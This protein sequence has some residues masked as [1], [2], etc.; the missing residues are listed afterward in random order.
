MKTFM[1]KLMM[2]IMTISSFALGLGSNALAATSLVYITPSS[3]AFTAGQSLTIY[4]RVNAQAPING[5]QANLTYPADKFNVSS[6]SYGGTAFGMEG[7][8][9]ASGGVIRMGR[10]TGSDVTG[11]HLVGTVNLVAKVN[12]GSAS[13]SFA[14]GTALANDVNSI[15]CT[16]SGGNYSF[17]IPATPVP[18][19]APVVKTPTPKPGTTA[20]PTLGAKTPT[21]MP[22]VTPTVTPLAAPDKPVV[23]G[24][25]LEGRTLGKTALFVTTNKDTKIILSY[26]LTSR[27]G[28][29]VMSSE[30]GKDHGVVLD[31][32]YL[33]PKTTYHYKINATDI[34]GNTLESE[35]KTFTTIG[36]PAHISVVGSDNLPLPGAKVTVDG[37]TITAD[38]KG[39]AKFDLG[40][41]QKT[42]TI[43][44]G[45]VTAIKNFVLNDSVT[46]DAPLTI[47][48]GM[49]VK[50]QPAYMLILGLMAVLLGLLGIGYYLAR[51]FNITN[52]TRLF[53]FTL[54]LAKS[55]PV[56]KSEPSSAE[57]QNVPEPKV[58]DALEPS[59]APA[60]KQITHETPGIAIH[61]DRAAKEIAGQAMPVSD[62]LVKDDKIPAHKPPK[63][64]SDMPDNLPGDHIL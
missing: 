55:F 14:G 4:V 16:T 42:A 44:Y 8:S 3:G 27:Y 22:G 19:A 26:G 12:T 53:T 17:Y 2:A 38:S 6:I 62:N 43:Q 7:E 59:E 63:T 48:A 24:T 30:I 18:T 23:T 33:L 29:T 5:V 49:Q 39:V 61:P 36:L 20:T 35:D 50:K 40:Y 32:K 46:A 28:L 47:V 31:S 15:P 57:P 58:K 21:L 52:M 41:G 25:K 37:E 60:V 34:S 11:D 54:Q 51:R 10:A 9:V 13:I 56:S 64:S 45:G 1:P